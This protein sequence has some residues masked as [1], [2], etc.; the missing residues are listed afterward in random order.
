MPSAEQDEER[1]DLGL[2][3]LFGKAC[4]AGIPIPVGREVRCRSTW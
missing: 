4:V 2:K 3:V 1:I